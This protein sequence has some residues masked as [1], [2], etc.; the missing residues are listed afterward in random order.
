M[1]RRYRPREVLRVWQRLGWRFSHQT[2][3]HAGLVRPDGR[4]PLAAPLSDARL[5]PG[6]F[7]SIARQAGFTGPQFRALM[8]EYR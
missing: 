4:H 1:P 7:A 2:G 3:R 5:D 8:E 6:T